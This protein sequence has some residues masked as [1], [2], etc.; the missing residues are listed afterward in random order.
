MVLDEI[1][2]AVKKINDDFLYNLM[3]LSSE[4]SKT[5]IS[6]IGISNDVKFLEMID[7]RVKSSLSE[8]EMIFNPYNATQL[9]D[10]LKKRAEE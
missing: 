9:K 6:I 8:E 10:I 1:D 2:Q 7:Q 5:Q 3:R 4:L